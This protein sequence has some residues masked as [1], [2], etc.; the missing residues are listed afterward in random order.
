MEL[1]D[2]FDGGFGWIEGGF[3]RRCAHALAADGRVWLVDP[4]EVDGLED[5][6]LATGE[7]G[8][9]IQLLD[10]HDRDCEGLAR[11]LGVPLYRLQAP[12]PFEAIPL[13]TTPGW[14]EIALWWPERRVLVVGDALGTA[15]YFRAGD[16]RLAVHP[17]LRPI[18]PRRLSRLAP[19]HVLVGHGEGVHEDAAGALAEALAT[20][21]RRMPAL[22]WDGFR[23]RVLK[24]R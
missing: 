1:C 14:K 16:E 24:R 18:P 22:L 12:P 17:L 11:Q 6:V 21:R 13:A 23:A 9:V 4:F 3:M 10:R 7:P 19:E 2:E 15:R 8:G 5:Q 20:A